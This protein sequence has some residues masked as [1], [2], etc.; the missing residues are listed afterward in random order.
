MGRKTK[1]DPKARE[2]ESLADL[3]L[4]FVLAPCIVLDALLMPCLERDLERSLEI[5]SD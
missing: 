1:H 3:L 2:A 5:S 4:D